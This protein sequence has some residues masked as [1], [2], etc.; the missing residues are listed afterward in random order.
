MIDRLRTTLYDQYRRH[1]GRIVIQDP[2][3][4]ARENPYTFQ[5]PSLQEIA[6]LQ[7]GHIVKLIFESVPTARAWGAERMWVKIT[8]RDGECF[9]GTLDNEPQD[10]PQLRLGDEISFQAH[11]VIAIFWTDPADR[12]R[13]D[14]PE[15]ERWFARAQV[16][17]R[18]TREGA[19]VR[20]IRRETPRSLPDTEYPDTG[21]RILSEPEGDW[22]EMETMPLAIGLV[23]NQDDSILPYLEAPVG[24]AF[25]RTDDHEVFAPAARLH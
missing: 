15:A 24:S 16:D 9:L 17:P 22:R 3:P 20:Y 1:F 10:M 8:H 25:R 13:F 11:Q 21:W 19:P 5:L 4:V 23:L 12:A 7:P 14:D 18:I 2:R 6:C